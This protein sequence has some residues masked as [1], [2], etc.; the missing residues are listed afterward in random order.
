MMLQPWPEELTLAG[1]RGLHL[2]ELVCLW[3]SVSSHS[4]LLRGEEGALL[5][6]VRQVV[7]LED[8]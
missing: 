8:T 2:L 1:R 4:C 3:N 6:Q 5:L 7:A